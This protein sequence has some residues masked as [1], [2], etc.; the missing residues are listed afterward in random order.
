MKA[1]LAA[2]V[3]LLNQLEASYTDLGPVYDCVVFHDGQVWR[4]CVDTSETGDLSKAT[5]M[6]DYWYAIIQSEC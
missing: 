6:T 1:D 4:A 3:V 5:L 2:R